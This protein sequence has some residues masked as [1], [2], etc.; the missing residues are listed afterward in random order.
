MFSPKHIYILNVRI[1]TST[2]LYESETWGENKRVKTD[3][4]KYKAFYVRSL[5]TVT[6][7]LRCRRSCGQN[8]LSV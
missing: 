4:A 7:V 6:D 2:F 3:A 8:V 1:I 5:E